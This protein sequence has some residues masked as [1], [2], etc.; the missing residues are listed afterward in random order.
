MGHHVGLAT[1]SDGVNESVLEVE[2]HTSPGQN[3]S[4][5]AWHVTIRGSLPQQLRVPYGKALSVVLADGSRGVGTLVDAHLIRGA[6]EPPC[7]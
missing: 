6:G 5:A 3:A 2:I 1:I 7:N 4:V